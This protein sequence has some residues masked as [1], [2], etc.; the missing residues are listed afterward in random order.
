MID[1]DPL[2]LHPWARQKMVALAELAVS[3][4]LFVHLQE[5]WRS[6]GEQMANWRRG[7]DEHGNVV[8]PKQVVTKARPGQSW[9]NLERW[10]LADGVWTRVP[11]SL[12]WHF[13]LK[14][15][16]DEGGLEGIGRNTLSAEDR[17][18]YAQL[19]AIGRDE[20]GLRWG[21]D[22]DGDGIP[23]EP[24]EWDLGH[25]EARMPGWTLGHVSAVLDIK[26]ADLVIDH[27]GRTT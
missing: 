21:G 4:G 2:H 27:G 24:G 18:R 25:F 10:V 1:K 13:Y 3:R 11:S 15:D 12:A 9:H 23:F 8:D 17:K 19:G 26:G 14:D 6:L 22:F 20:L 5:T 7:R 16:G